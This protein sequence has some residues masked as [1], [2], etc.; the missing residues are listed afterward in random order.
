MAD[1]IPLSLNIST[2]A[3]LVG[4]A[5]RK[6]GVVLFLCRLADY[7][8]SN[9]SIRSPYHARNDRGPRFS[10]DVPQRFPGG[11]HL[12]EAS[13]RDRIRYLHPLSRAS[14]LE[15]HVDV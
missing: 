2:E 6:H 10:A 11:W 12:L 15:K 1:V 5:E 4:L 13:H 9:A 14:V 8:S 3:E 7:R